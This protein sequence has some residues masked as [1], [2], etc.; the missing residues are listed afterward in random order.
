MSQELIIHNISSHQNQLLSPFDR[1]L[2]WLHFYLVNHQTQLYLSVAFPILFILHR[3]LFIL[4]SSQG[5]ITCIA[6]GKTYVNKRTN[7]LTFYFFTREIHIP[8]ISLPS[9]LFIPSN[10]FTRFT[11]I[12][13]YLHIRPLQEI[14]VKKAV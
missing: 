9:V 1:I 6:E 4:V 5:P 10:F 7:I 13:W 12:V 14:Q 11:N 3:T 8:T 2:V